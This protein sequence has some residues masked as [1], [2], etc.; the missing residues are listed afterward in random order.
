MTSLETMAGIART[1]TALAEVMTP[2]Q[3][4]IAADKLRAMDGDD[5][6]RGFFAS[7]ADAL[8]QFAAMEER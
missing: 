1:I 4:H 5:A 7:T 6:T 8:E 3:R 2:D